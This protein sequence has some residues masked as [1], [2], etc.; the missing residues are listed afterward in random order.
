MITSAAI[1]K[2]LDPNHTGHGERRTQANEFAATSCEVG[3]VP[4]NG[5]RG[6]LWRRRARPGEWN[7]RLLMA[8]SAASRRMEFAATDGEVGRVPANGIRGYARHE[9][10][11]RRLRRRVRT[12][13]RPRT[14]R[15]LSIQYSI[16][17]VLTNAWACFAPRRIS[18]F[19]LEYRKTTYRGVR[20]R[21]T[22]MRRMKDER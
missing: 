5:I 10:G 14:G 15:R 19:H 20:D 3:R 12:L 7:S 18:R 8:K 4:A 17:K 2:R 1:R 11:L 6:Y 21:L 13:I 22:T 9:V 16:I